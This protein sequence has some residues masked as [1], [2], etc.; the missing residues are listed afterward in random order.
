MPAA[1]HDTVVQ[2]KTNALPDPRFMAPLEPSPVMQHPTE[3]STDIDRSSYL[4]WIRSFSELGMD[5]ASTSRGFLRYGPMSV[6]DAIS[7]KVKRSKVGW[8]LGDIISTDGAISRLP[9]HVAVS[10]RCLVSYHWVYGPQMGHM[11]V[12]CP[13]Q[14]LVSRRSSNR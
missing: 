14:L 3:M 11:E 12:H 10:P 8:S 2:S 9:C 4:V 5:G 6:Y 7:S 13:P 1:V